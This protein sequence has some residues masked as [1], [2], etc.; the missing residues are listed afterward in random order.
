MAVW[1]HLNVDKAHIAYAVIGVFSAVFSLISLF[2]KEKLYIGEATVAA[3]VGLI[4]G[5]HCLNWFAPTTWGNSDYITLEISRIVLCLQIFAVAVELP[6]KY[7]LK[8]W[9]S[10]A[11]LLVPVMTAGWLV[12]GLFIWI[13]IP[14]LNFSESLVAAACVTATDPVL[15]AAVVGKGKFARRVPGHLRNLLTAESGCNDGMAFPF[16]YL[17]INLVI[18]WGN[19]REIVKDWICVTI[20]YECLFGCILGVFI[21]YV[22]RH[23]IKYAE[24]KGLI[25]RES[26]LAFYLVLAFACAGFGSM[27]G[28]DDLL[29]SFAA[30]T[31]FSWDGWFARKTEETHVSTVIDLLLNLSYFV[32]FGAIIPWPQFNNHELGLDVWRLI[33]LSIV[34]I[35]LRRLPAVLALKPFIPD[36]KTWREAFFVGHFGPIGVGAVF[37]AI[38]ARGELE[39]AHTLEATP[40]A[41]LPD[42]SSEY[43]QLIAVIWPI[44]TF[45]IITSII[46][47]G[48]SVAVITLGRHLNTMAISMSF[49]TTNGNGNS[50]S[51]MSRLPELKSNG[52]SFSLHRV[53]TMAPS[54]ASGNGQLSQ[55]PTVETSGIPA[56]PAGGMERRKKKSKKHGKHRK[57]GLGLK[58]IGSHHAQDRDDGQ[59][60]SEKLLREREAKAASFALGGRPKQQSDQD[61]DSFVNQGITPANTFSEKVPWPTSGDDEEAQ[62][63]K[64]QHEPIEEST[65]SESVAEKQESSESGENYERNRRPSAAYTEGNQLIIE[66]QHG[67]I[68]DT[69]KM[70]VPER[71]K[72]KQSKQ[73]SKKTSASKRSKSPASSLSSITRKS[74]S[75]LERVNSGGKA[76]PKYTAYK[77]DNQLVIENED[78]EIIRRYK[79]NHHKT[80]QQRS[81]ASTM[82]G[83]IGKALSAVGIKSSLGESPKEAAV[84]H[85]ALEPIQQP[86]HPEDEDVDSE[87]E[88]D[89]ELEEQSQEED[90]SE[91]DDDDDD[92]VEDSEGEEQGGIDDVEETEV[93]R[94]RRLTALGQFAAPRDEEDEE[95]GVQVQPRSQPVDQQQSS[96]ST[97]TG[98]SSKNVVKALGRGFKKQQNTPSVQDYANIRPTNSLTFQEPKKG[99][100]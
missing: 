46:V 23:S 7:M 25:D 30:G 17:G 56:R 19:G 54:L 55:A 72:R 74:S 4:V 67:E 85:L 81:R 79:I 35:F 83:G 77:L 8:H 80:T 37:A 36:V 5:P 99:S 24:K 97:T 38:L 41:H 49:T 31:A 69:A 20:L 78:G 57:R 22:G 68:L 100:S 73:S 64:P 62:L 28:T 12:V 87:E 44:T 92:E 88:E 13:V 51:W 34:I 18:H 1:E 94:A 52:R 71:M 96:A 89:S 43:Y 86:E 60:D 70:D 45:L 16:I 27:L 39:G 29:V 2:V 58:K 53:D 76:N 91:E 48:S 15:A 14:G 61:P 65:E 40:L 59:V 84:D 66:D 93:E 47:H 3:I 95:E 98:T 21:G 11:M 42:E 82:A 63:P 90:D 10:V 26:F 6:K 75:I 9:W 33:I 32:Y 50:T